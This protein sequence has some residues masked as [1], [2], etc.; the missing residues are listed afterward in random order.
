MGQGH[1]GERN[2][3]ELT[4]FLS[5]HIRLAAAVLLSLAM[6]APTASH[7]ADQTVLGA[8]NQAAQQLASRSPL[9][10][11]AMALITQRIAQ[12][13][14]PALRAAT[15]DAATNPLTC[16]AHRAHL[17]EA[18]KAEIVR[19]L[20]VQGL[21]DAA[22]ERAISGGLR[23]GIFPPLA[24]E[25]S[26]CP[27]LPQPYATAPAGDNHHSYP[28]GLA[29]H[30]AV[31]LSASLS[32]ADN[33]RRIFGSTAANGLAE[34][35]NAPPPPGQS[36]VAIDQDLIIA[37]PVW[38]DWAKT[39]VFQW[40]E[41]GTEFAEIAF[42]GNGKTDDYGGP[43]NS[44]T[45]A[46]HMIALAESMARKLPPAFVVTQASAH[47][48]PTRGNEFKVVNWLRAAAIIARIDPIAAGYLIKDARDRLRLPVLRKQ[49]TLNIQA[50]LP[51]QGN[52]LVEYALHNL[53]DA[54]AVFSTP[55]IVQAQQLLATLAP[56]FGYDSN[57]R[58]AYNTKYRN[59]VLSYFSAERL[60]IIY[61]NAGLDAVA[62][63]IAKL[64]AMGII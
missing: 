7:G 40:N 14:D 18:N 29:V 52:L 41:D 15:L 12:I 2:R 51:N 60:Q 44:K 11:S 43:G 1:Q 55:A 3:T 16:L 19:E 8:G 28:G 17:T 54:D 21:V 30:V 59:P 61:V 42:G 46:H 10:N 49:G 33:Y 62:S 20:L 26:T 22:E 64:K 45:P 48:A 5:L 35:A 23:A 24:D 13:I 50:S 53:S 38:H 6:A 37:A 32:L 39:I 27:H 47:V 57:Q 58:A 9:V 63:E 4:S 31:N 56:K 25:G 36:A 34:I